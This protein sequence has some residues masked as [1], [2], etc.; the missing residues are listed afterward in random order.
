[1]LAS[2]CPVRNWDVQLSGFSSKLIHDRRVSRE[3]LSAWQGQTRSPFSLRMFPGDHFFLQSAQ[4]PVL[5][6]LAQDLRLVLRRLTKP[7]NA[8]P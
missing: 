5:L 2:T 6:V 4:S 3:E 1:M 8:K 7:H